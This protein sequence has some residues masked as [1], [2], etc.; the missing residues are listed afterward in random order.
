[1]FV[2]GFSEG[3]RRDELERSY[4]F[5]AERAVESLYHD[6][7][8]ATARAAVERLRP[9]ARID[10]VGAELPDVERVSIVGSLDRAIRPDWSRRAARELL[11]VEPVELEAAHSP[12]LSRPAELAALLL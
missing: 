10:D 4:W 5:D 8:P 9:Q 3:R 1:M 11:G 6:C 7:D 2:P 12:M